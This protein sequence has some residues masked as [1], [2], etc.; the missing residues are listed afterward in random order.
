MFSES[1]NE[2]SL[3]RPSL[4]FL[5]MASHR[6][7]YRSLFITDPSG[8]DG[9][10]K[11]SMLVP[12]EWGSIQVLNIFRLLDTTD[13]NQWFSCWFLLMAD[14]TDDLRTKSGLGSISAET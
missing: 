9:E 3:L 7:L 12:P 6:T 13:L 1:S 11:T 5:H 2:F 14:F 10:G 8:V 4:E